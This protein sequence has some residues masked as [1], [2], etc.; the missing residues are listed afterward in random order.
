MLRTNFEMLVSISSIPVMTFLKPCIEDCLQNDA[1][2][3]EKA[4]SSGTVSFSLSFSIVVDIIDNIAIE[5][6][7]FLS[8][9]RLSYQNK[10]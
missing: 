1:V 5:T 10:S 2:V 4:S 7:H 9:L 3:S 6:I 8:M